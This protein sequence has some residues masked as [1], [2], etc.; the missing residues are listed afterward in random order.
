[1][2][3]KCPFDQA[4]LKQL[5]ERMGEPYFH[6]SS[7][8]QDYSR[9]EVGNLLR[10]RRERLDHARLELAQLDK[11]RSENFKIFKSCTKLT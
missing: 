6:C 2:T 4:E 9:Y 1:M 3:Y 10:V 5:T 8:K 11:R 7:C